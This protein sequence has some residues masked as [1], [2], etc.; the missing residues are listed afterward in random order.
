[1]NNFKIQYLHV[2]NLAIARIEETNAGIHSRTSCTGP[3]NTGFRHLI[4]VPGRFWHRDF[5]S[6]RYQNDRLPEVPAFY[7]TNNSLEENGFSNFHKTIIYQNIYILYE[8]SRKS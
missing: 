7:S 2:Y 4:P 3:E 6:F 1:M 8:C 5:F